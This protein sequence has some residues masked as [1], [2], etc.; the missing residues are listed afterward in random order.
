MLKVTL[1]LAYNDDDN[2]AND[3]NFMQSQGLCSDSRFLMLLLMM[4]LT[5][6]TMVTIE[7][8]PAELFLD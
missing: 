1:S 6:M 7:R 2:D 3:Y 8:R 5:M 4:M